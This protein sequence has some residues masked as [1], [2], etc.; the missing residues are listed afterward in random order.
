[1]RRAGE[2]V[3]QGEHLEKMRH[4]YTRNKRRRKLACYTWI[5]AGKHWDS[6][7]IDG[8]QLLSRGTIRP[9]HMSGYRT[10]GAQR[11][12]KRARVMAVQE[13]ERVGNE[14]AG[15]KQRACTHTHTPTRSG[16]LS[17]TA[18]T[19]VCVCV[20]VCVCDATTAPNATDIRAA[21]QAERHGEGWSGAPVVGELR[22]GRCV[23]CCM[24]AHPKSCKKGAIIDGVKRWTV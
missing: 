16:R 4:K 7:V 3:T 21:R 19:N 12:A 6:Q 9:W 13:A 15:T 8:Q 22:F 5:G 14:P 23:G 18:R 1:L 24:T 2:E 11:V 10:S 17:L 20:C